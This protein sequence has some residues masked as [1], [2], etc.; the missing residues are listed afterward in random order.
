[1]V[2]PISPDT[3]KGYDW[4]KNQPENKNKKPFYEQAS[5]PAKDITPKKYKS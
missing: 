5:A 4:W 3:G 1:M 2:K